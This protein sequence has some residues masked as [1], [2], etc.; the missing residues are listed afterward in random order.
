MSQIRSLLPSLL[1]VVVPL[2]HLGSH[3]PCTLIVWLSA[4]LCVCFPGHRSASIILGVPRGR[5]GRGTAAL[6]SRHSDQL[7][8]FKREK[9]AARSRDCFTQTG[10]R[11]GAT[12]RRAT[13][14]A[15]IHLSLSRAAQFGRCGS[16][17]R[18][19]PAP[20]QTRHAQ[21]IRAETA[22]RA[23]RRSFDALYLSS[24]LTQTAP[25]DPRLPVIL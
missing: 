14:I 5:V 3:W 15:Q 17:R 21:R 9:S 10:E 11:N 12:I 1:F 8:P 4:L 20:E 19:V 7:Q 25:F 6:L 13:R 2:V 23:T 16:C 22:A 24:R 18:I